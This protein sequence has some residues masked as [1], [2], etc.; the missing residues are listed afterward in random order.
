MEFYFF[1]MQQSKVFISGCL[2]STWW[3]KNPG[4]LYVEAVPIARALS[5]SVEEKGSVKQLYL[6]LKLLTRN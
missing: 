2:S 1:L 3:F 4:S 6:F 5:S